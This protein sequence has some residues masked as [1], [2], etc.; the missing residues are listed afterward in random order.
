MDYY[1]FI[2]L[3]Q[4]LTLLL[5][6]EYSGMISA[7]R[8]L[9]LLSSSDSPASASRVAGITG[10]CHRAQLICCILGETKFHH[11]GQADLELLTSDDAGLGFP[12]CWDCGSESPHLAYIVVL[13]CTFFGCF[14]YSPV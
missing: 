13:I 8:S 6:L 1:L 10:M 11:V 3:R 14:T 7:H 4:G 5:R 2:Y 12:M 9:R